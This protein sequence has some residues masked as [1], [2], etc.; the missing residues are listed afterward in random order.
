MLQKSIVISHVAL[1]VA[2]Y[3]L[4]IEISN[5]IFYPYYFPLQIL[6]TYKYSIYTETEKVHDNNMLYQS[7]G[8]SLNR[9]AGTD[10]I[11]LPLLLT[12]TLRKLSKMYHVSIHRH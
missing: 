9:Q 3:I 12:I 8:Q 6:A 10:A 2:C 5:V 1:Y 11:M 4:L 7:T